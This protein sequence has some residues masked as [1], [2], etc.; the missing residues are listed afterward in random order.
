MKS[1][2]TSGEQIEKPKTKEEE[3]EEAHKNVIARLNEIREVFFKT[4][5]E[6][7]KKAR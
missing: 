1:N 7:S 3:V 4:Y 2:S 6:L 5:S